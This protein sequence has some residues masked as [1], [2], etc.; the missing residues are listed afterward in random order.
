MGNKRKK[1]REIDV[2][3]LAGDL[4]HQGGYGLSFFSSSP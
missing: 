1:E 3:A 4:R 2:E